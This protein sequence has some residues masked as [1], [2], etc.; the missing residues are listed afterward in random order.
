[1]IKR[2]VISLLILVLSAAAVLTAEAAVSCALP[3]ALKTVPKDIADLPLPDR[4]PPYVRIQTFGIDENGAIHLELSDTVPQLRILEQNLHDDDESTIFT[5]RNAS[6]ADAHMTGTEYSFFIIR[7]IWQLGG[8]EYV[9]EYSNASGDLCFVSCTVSGT[10]D[11]SAFGPYASAVRTLEF[12][13]AGI[14]FSETWTLEN[15]KD[16]FIRAAVYDQTGSLASVKQVW[17]SV[18]ADDYRYIIEMSGDGGM[19]AMT[20][21]DRKN[22]FYMSNVRPDRQPDAVL[23]LL[24][25]VLD[26]TAFEEQL[27]RK[28]PQLSHGPASIPADTRIWALN[29][30]DFIESDVY[31]FI[32]ADPVIILKDGMAALNLNAK[33]INGD[34]IRLRK[35]R[36]TSPVMEIVAIQ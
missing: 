4:L 12:S 36:I 31:A 13:E 30:G 22:R 15:E 20:V 11:P 17:E 10:A 32:S 19:T 9:R 28:Y 24:T 1:M 8:M 25:E 3:A 23:E 35:N 26:P 21:E 2:A 6:S 33:D 16:R 27:D 14:P 34:K 7:M 5:K 29:F 18:K